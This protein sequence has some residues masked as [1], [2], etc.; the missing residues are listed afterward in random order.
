M[1]KLDR[2]ILEPLVMLALREDMPYGDI[3]TE[4]TVPDDTPCRAVISSKEE[5]VLAGTLCVEM[6][7]QL[8]DPGVALE[9][10]K[11]DGDF[12]KPGT[13]IVRLEGEASSLLKGER[14]ALNF[15]QH[16]SGIATYTRRFVEAV[17][18]LPVRICDTRKT[19]P[20]LRYLEKY[21]VRVGG[22]HNHRFSLS[23]A[24]LVKD[25]HITVC[26]GVGKAVRRAMGKRPHPYGVEVEVDS[27]EGL[28]E[29][30]EAGADAILLDNMTV[31]ELREAVRLSREKAP[32]VE[33][34]ASGGVSLENVRAIAETGVDIISI[35]ALT[36][37]AP[38]VDIAMDFLMP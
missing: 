3:T 19:T 2:V 33:L 12:I 15:L 22:G 20:G 26:G 30:L 21:A 34:E 32:R 23:D 1:Y 36:H 25:N 13:D 7:F 28:M 9:F 6:V 35:G 14:V 5:L 31:E 29:A 24:I 11:K 4:V 10:L 27:M 16:L 37:S 17:Q 18:G 8:T 38:N